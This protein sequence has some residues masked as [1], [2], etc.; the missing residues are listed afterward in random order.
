MQQAWYHLLPP[1]QEPRDTSTQLNKE[2]KGI[3]EQR[4]NGVWGN[5][6][7]GNIAR[8]E[9]LLCYHCWDSFRFRYQCMWQM[10]LHPPPPSP[11]CGLSSA[12][13]PSLSQ[14]AGAKSAPQH[15]SSCYGLQGLGLLLFYQSIK[16]QFQVRR[17]VVHWD[18]DPATVPPGHV[19]SGSPSLLWWLVRTW[20]WSLPQRWGL[21]SRAA[22]WASTGSGLW[23]CT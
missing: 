11:A 17:V 6:T 18:K 19:L 4:A 5:T 13:K 9:S 10:F 1:A 20:G 14:A 21:V 8:G 12:P 22:S 15:H 23:P 3:G 7:A 2:S 16:H